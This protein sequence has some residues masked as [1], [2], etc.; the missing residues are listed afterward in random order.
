[1]ELE[2]YLKSILSSQTIAPDSNEMKL[3]QESKEEVEELL[4]AA[5]SESNPTILPAGSKAKGTMI[6]D[7]YDLDLICYFEHDDNGAGETLKDIYDNVAEFLDDSYYVERKNS[8][9]RIKSRDKQMDYHIDVVPGRFVDDTKTYANLYQADGEKD[10]LKTNLNIHINY[11][12]NSGLTDVIRLAKLWKI[13]TGLQVKTFVLELMVV[14]Y[15]KKSTNNPLSTGLESFWQYLKEHG[16]NITVEDPANREG[17][18]LSGFLS[19]ST[20]Q[21]LNYHA[22]VALSSLNEGSW[23]DVFGE[24]GKMVGAERVEAL[25]AVAATLPSSPKPWTT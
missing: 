12:K 19:D 22:E 6:K 2:E 13:K 23:A 3:L 15:A 7:S 18:D 21:L 14:A 17:N 24:A 8:A 9:L 20:K 4:Q 10:W 5:F 16:N 25:R 11:I 1:M